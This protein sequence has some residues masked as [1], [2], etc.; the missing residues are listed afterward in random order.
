MARF[1]INPAT[2]ETGAC[3]ATIKCPFGDMEHDHYD[4][5]ESARSAYEKKAEAEYTRT[6][7]LKRPA[8][9][10]APARIF[11][12]SGSRE[13]VGSVMGKDYSSVISNAKDRAAMA[14]S[15]FS[16]PAPAASLDMARH[17]EAASAETRTGA[18]AALAARRTSAAS[19]KASLSSVATASTAS[20]TDT[21]AALA[22]RTSTGSKFLAGAR[23]M[24]NAA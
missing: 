18:T 11:A 22:A 13:L 23:S 17:T 2:G 21:R 10:A 3:K 12:S 14:S 16:K 5:A 19:G 7:S 24:A 9:A 4:S 6:G 20:A 8:A 15:Y 1:H